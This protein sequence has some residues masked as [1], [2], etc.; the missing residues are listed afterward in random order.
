[1]MGIKPGDVGRCSEEQRRPADHPVT[2]LTE[3]RSRSVFRLVFHYWDATD[4]CS[5]GHAPPGLASPG[6]RHDARR[7]PPP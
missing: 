1:M 2:L 4:R 6:N 7:R 5:S 3:V